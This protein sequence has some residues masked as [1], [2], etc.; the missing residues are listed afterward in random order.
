MKNSLRKFKQY[1]LDMASKK[2]TMGGRCGN[3]CDDYWLSS[4]CYALSD[5][6]DWVF[7]TCSHAR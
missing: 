6:A 4:A 2:S 5:A 3:A 1:E 7:G